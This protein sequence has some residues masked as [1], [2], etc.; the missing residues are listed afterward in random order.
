MMD[1]TWEDIGRTRVLN[2]LFSFCE[3]EH[4]CKLEKADIWSQA[5]GIH[6]ILFLFS[7]TREKRQERDVKASLAVP[8]YIKNQKYLTLPRVRTLGTLRYELYP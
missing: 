2:V 8:R 6:F 3:L 5:F 4:V 7:K 1:A